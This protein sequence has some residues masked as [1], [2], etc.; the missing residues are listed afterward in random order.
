MWKVVL[1]LLYLE[2]SSPFF[3]TLYCYDKYPLYNNVRIVKDYN[4]SMGLENSNKNK[5]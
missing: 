2:Y 4:S 5:L 3:F 1:E